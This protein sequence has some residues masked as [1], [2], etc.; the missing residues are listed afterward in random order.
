M[1]AITAGCCSPY[2]VSIVT[3]LGDSVVTTLKIMA[4]TSD[5]VPSKCQ[6]GF[7]TTPGTVEMRE[8]REV[9]LTWR[10]ARFDVCCLL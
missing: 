7:Y 3:G 10:D 2:I 9:I 4:A 6:A 8:V 5:S 1:M